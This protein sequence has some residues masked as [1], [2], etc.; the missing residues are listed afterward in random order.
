MEIARAL[1]GWKP[2]GMRESGNLLGWRCKRTHLVQN[3]TSLIEICSDPIK[4]R[5]AAIELRLGPT[6]MRSG[7]IELRLG[8]TEMCTAAIDLRL[9]RTE[10]CSRR[11]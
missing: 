8:L 7:A 6:E 3:V 10:M 5:S 1:T 9:H 2:K 11:N 4:M